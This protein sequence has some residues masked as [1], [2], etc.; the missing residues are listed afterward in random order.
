MKTF[1]L[2]SAL[3]EKGAN[4]KNRVVVNNSLNINQIPSFCDTK[5]F[6][7]LFVP[8]LTIIGDSREQDR[9][10]EQACRYHGINYI[11]AIKS[12]EMEN[13]KEGDYTFRLDFTNKIKYDYVDRVAYERKGTISELY[14][15]CIDDRKRLKNEFDRFV[16][17]EYDKQVLLLEFGENLADL[18]D[19]KF[20]IIQKGATRTVYAGKVIFSTVQSWKQPNNKDFEVI[21]SESREK[22]FWLM[23][24]DMYYFWRNEVRNEFEREA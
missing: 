15:N 21:Q 12:E 3:V 18:S 6:K 9:W 13:L 22:L 5:D 23:L 16:E 7:E 8:Y 17:K 10:V 20:D 14:N 2:S 11:R 4:K 1:R 19:L 24:N